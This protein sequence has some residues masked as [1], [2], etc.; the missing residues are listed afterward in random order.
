MSEH[1]DGVLDHKLLVASYMQQVASALFQRAVSHD[2]SK[3]SAEE[4][5]TFE[6]VT[7]LL[8]TLVYG[9]DEYKAALARMGPALAH[10][11]AVN[12]HHPEFYPDGVNGM[13][14]I[15]LIE[16]LCDWL[17]AVQRV[18]NGD[19]YASMPINKERFHIDDQLYGILYHT[20]TALK[21]DNA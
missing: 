18:K 21:E 4:M 3:F 11:Y 7:P 6:E 19:I 13:T 2:Y 10:H 17:A 20:V 1:I 16:M 14:L 15:D 9:S 12:S 8:K 5:A